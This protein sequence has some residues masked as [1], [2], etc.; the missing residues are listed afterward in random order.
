MVAVSS[1]VSIQYRRR[2]MRPSR[3]SIRSLPPKK[4][5]FR[6]VRQSG[7]TLSRARHG[8]PMTAEDTLHHLVAVSAI[9]AAP[10]GAAASR[11]KSAVTWRANSASSGAGRSPQTSRSNPPQ[12]FGRCGRSRCH[13]RGRY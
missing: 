12:T 5:A 8:H 4:G 1:D 7:A 10:S 9:C 3:Q 11:G 13:G 6:Q 2:R